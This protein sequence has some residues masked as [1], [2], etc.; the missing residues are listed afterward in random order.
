MDKRG[1]PWAKMVSNCGDVAG[2]KA[3]GEARTRDLILTMDALY[4]LS[5]V[6]ADGKS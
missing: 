4:Q 1:Q 5:Y 3:D 2:K 6:G